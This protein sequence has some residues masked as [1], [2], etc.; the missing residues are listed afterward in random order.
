MHEIDEKY[1]VSP[2]RDFLL[3]T[4]QGLSES[5]TDFVAQE[6]WKTFDEGLYLGHMPK[7]LLSFDS[8]YEIVSLADNYFF[9]EKYNCNINDLPAIDQQYDHDMELFAKFMWLFNEHRTTGFVNPIGVHLNPRTQQ[10]VIHPGGCRNKVLKYFH[11]GPIYCVF[12]N[13][14]G[15]RAD[16]MQNLR[17]IS[18]KDFKNRHP[19]TLGL[20][21]DH[22][23]LIPHFLVQ[24]DI[25]PNGIET[26]HKKIQARL[27][28]LRVTS[29]A[30]TRWLDPWLVNNK[31]NV[32]I[33]YK[34]DTPKESEFKGLVHMISG[35][36]FE[37]E[38]WSIVC[39]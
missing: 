8:D 19:S 36:N 17:P 16:W 23:S 27:N 3:E 29:N 11:N 14:K 18:I 38:H 31:P 39:N 37:D 15:Y 6:S 12:F 1:Q 13:T 22:G 10:F 4:I 21:P 7:E 9:N 30:G 28:E 33:T 20:V 26:W 5:D 34:Q 24:V 2:D 25:I 35:F 32:T